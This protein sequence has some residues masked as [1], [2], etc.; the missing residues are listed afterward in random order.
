MRAPIHGRGAGQGGGILNSTQPRK[1][2][3]ERVN[4]MGQANVSLNHSRLT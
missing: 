3:I 1:K 4:G 2:G